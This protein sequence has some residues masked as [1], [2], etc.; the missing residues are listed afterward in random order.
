M[1]HLEY[2]MPVHPASGAIHVFFWGLP[3][4]QFR[5]VSLQD[6]L[7]ELIHL[8]PGTIENTSI[9]HFKYFSFILWCFKSWL[10]IIFAAWPWLHHV[11]SLCMMAG[12]PCLPLPVVGH[13]ECQCCEWSSAAHH[14]QLGKP[15][16]FG[17]PDPLPKGVLSADYSGIF[18]EYDILGLNVRKPSIILKIHWIGRE[19]CGDFSHWIGGHDMLVSF[20][21][22]QWIEPVVRSAAEPWLSI[23]AKKWA[24]KEQWVS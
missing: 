22:P 3:R 24:A 19:I 10:L 20:N 1:H 9:S 11:P 2:F 17:A 7:S 21:Q 8:I 15:W 12:S 13:W 14:E 18:C 4:G 16:Y 23:F 5:S 6:L